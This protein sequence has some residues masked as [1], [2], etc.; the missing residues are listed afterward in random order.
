VWFPEG[1]G[2][3]VKKVED[4]KVSL[5][6]CVNYSTPMKNVTGL[7]LLLFDLGYSFTDEDAQWDD[8]P[9]N[10]EDMDKMNE[11]YNNTIVASWR[12]SSGFPLSEIDGLKYFPKIVHTQEVLSEDGDITELYHWAVPL[13]CPETDEEVIVN[14]QDYSLLYGAEALHRVLHGSDIPSTHKRE[15]GGVN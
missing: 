7:K 15:D 13:R 5:V 11:D 12:T 10:E 9:L 6:R 2:F 3:I 1:G 8:V 14:P 4:K